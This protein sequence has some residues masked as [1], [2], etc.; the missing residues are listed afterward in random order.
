MLSVSALDAAASVRLTT[1]TSG[2][3]RL[4]DSRA[5]ASDCATTGV[6]PKL[7]NDCARPSSSG[8]SVP[9]NR[10]CVIDSCLCADGGGQSACGTCG[11]FPYR[12]L[13]DSD[14]LDDLRPRAVT[15]EY[16]NVPSRNCEDP[17]EKIHE[18]RV[19]RA[20]DGRCREPHFE[21]VT[22]NS[23]DLGLRRPR[24]HSN[25]KADAAVRFRNAKPVHRR[26][27]PRLADR[28][29][30]SSSQATIGV[31]SSMPMRG[32]MRCSGRIIQSVSTYDH[33][34]HLEYGETGNQDDSTR[35]NKAS[36]S[37]EIV[38]PTMTRHAI[39][40]VCVIAT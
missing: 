39:S 12:S 29:S 6:N 37:S 1:A 19:G 21:R 33:R 27:Q 34:I 18:R 38:Q 23:G 26:I 24:L 11:D 22:V 3:W 10:I 16:D 5:S 30:D 4:A 8:S 31:M 9:I 7:A 2:G 28:R 36:V 35:T 15:G 20:V 25:G 32:T 14:D 13:G 17:G 40:G